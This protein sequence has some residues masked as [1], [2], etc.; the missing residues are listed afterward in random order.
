MKYVIRITAAFLCFVLLLSGCSDKTGTATP[1]EDMQALL[2]SYNNAKTRLVQSTDLTLSTA[3]KCDRTVGNQTYTQSNIANVSYSGHGREDMTALVQETLR[4]GTFEET[5]IKFYTG[6]TAYFRTK[7]CTFRAS[8]SAAEFT[9]RQLP[10]ALL[11]SALYQKASSA[12]FGNTTV[13]TFTDATAIESW[14]TDSENVQLLSACATATI[15]AAGNL[16]ETTYNADFIADGFVC[17][18]EATVS[19]NAEESLDLSVQLPSTENCTPIDCYDAPKLLLQ[20]V[21]N[22]FTATAISASYQENFVCS[23]VNLVQNSQADIHLSGTGDDFMAKAEYVTTET[24]YTGQSVTNTMSETFLEGVYS[25]CQ[26][27]GKPVIQTGTTATTVRAGFEDLLLSGLFTPAHI[28]NTTLTDT[29]DF[30]YIQF[31]GNHTFVTA[32]CNWLYSGMGVDLNDHASSATTKEAS[33]WLAINKRTG[34]PTAIGQTLQ[35]DYVIENVSYPLTYSFSQ[36][37][38]LSSESAYKAI[39]GTL[40]PEAQ[41][42]TTATPLLYKVTGGNGQQLWLFGTIHVGDTRTGFLPQELYNAFHSSDAL[43]VEIDLEA[44]EKQLE[45]DAALQQLI[46]AGYYYLD[47][48]SLYDHLSSE[49]YES[50]RKMLQITGQYSPA[51]ELMK[52][53]LWENTINNFLLQQS[54]S[55]IAEKGAES[56][57]Q[58]LAAK[59]GKPVWDIESPAEH[60]LVTATCSA[61]LQEYLLQSTLELSVSQYQNE[62]SELYELWCQG[63]ETALTNALREDTSQF[64]PEE[65]ALYSEHYTALIVNRNAVMLE[66]AKQYLE[67][68]ST[69]FFAVGLAHV[70]GDNGLAAALRDIGYSVEPVSYAG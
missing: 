3:Y 46:A 21:G 8:M 67:S 45:T 33:G 65:L 47:G 42:E 57:L 36:S 68:E 32:L 48:T 60:A 31:T 43:A 63:N 54:Y 15:D 50:A 44:F 59:A 41:P 24:N 56:R 27:G 2:T 26:N 9:A 1:T 53:S 16:T 5:Y 37:L 40:Q 4:Q 49:I 28:Q 23:A 17:H 29:G 20:A 51:A 39:T 66:K 10:A 69:V 19:P 13:I 6:Q 58:A 55:L 38:Y 7:E 14:V 35:R 18:V 62:I 70:L 52:A 34:L 25:Y 61:A 64:T 30:Y 11:D 22:I 12:V